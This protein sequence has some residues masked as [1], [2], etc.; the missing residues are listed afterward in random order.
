M[1]SIECAKA[2]DMRKDG[3]SVVVIAKKL[4]VSRGSVS[5]WVRDIEL[6]QEQKQ[7]LSDNSSI[8]LRQSLGAQQNHILAVA[9]R[10]EMRKKGFNR[11]RN[12]NSFRVICALYWGEG[13]KGHNGGVS[14][15]NADSD[16][17][18]LFGD[19]LVKEGYGDG[20]VFRVFYYGE[21]G[22]S[23]EEIKKWWMDKMSFLCQENIR[24]FTK[25]VI[26]R[27]SQKKKIGKLP[28]GTG[29]LQVGKCDLWE[30]IMGGID[31]LKENGI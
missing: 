10:A 6:S 17:L 20:M 29:H 9:R 24:K 19:W 14:I 1:K 8:W 23:E 25:C 26:N 4:R 22:I 13:G 30:E 12:D 11:A 5:L 16:V 3:C 31:Y 15:S 21:N 27:A 28:Y 7:K 18:R 2:R